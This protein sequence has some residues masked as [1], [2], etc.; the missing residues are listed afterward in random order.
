MDMLPPGGI[1]LRAG[2]DRNVP[3]IDQSR[4]PFVGGS[5]GVSDRYV[6]TR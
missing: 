3:V 1:R 6:Q 2:G 4:W 5:K